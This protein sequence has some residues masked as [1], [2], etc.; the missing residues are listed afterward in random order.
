MDYKGTKLNHIKNLD[1]T[2]KVANMLLFGEI[3]NQRNEGRFDGDEFAR[4][5]VFLSEV[6]FKKIR[7]H[8]NSVGGGIIKG[9][10]IINSMNVVRMNGSSIETIIVG[11]ADSM[12]GIISAFG[13]RGKRTVANFGS[14]IVHEPMVLIDG[15]LI[16]IDK[17]EDE[18]LKTEA[19]AALESLILLMV[20]STGKDK[21][22]VKEVM[23]KGKRLNATQLKDFG[24]VDKVVQLSNESVDIKNKTAIELMA[25]C[26]KIEVESKS[27]KMKEVNKTLNLSEDAAENSAVTAI[28][29]LQNKVKDQK[30]LLETET[31]KVTK[32]KGEKEVLVN[33]AKD[34]SDKS[35]ESFVDALINSGK[36]KK[37]NREALVNQAKDNFDGF[38]SITDSLEVTFVDIT[39]EINKEKKGDKD[40][41][42]AKEFFN[43]IENDTVDSFEKENPVKFEKMQ[44]AYMNSSTDFAKLN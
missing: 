19:L 15:K 30:T 2:E 1:E 20:T 6:G 42:L 8:I 44:K 33:A 28:L 10:S 12:A 17:I 5:M 25:A 27:K 22:I 43:L 4:E 39:K 14:G 7:I 35:A 31:G 18:S 29:A 26:S 21:K 41:V 38:K 13:D 16:T 11:I 9:M 40:E 36:L 24:M 23:S 34:V 3:S 37:E 32:L